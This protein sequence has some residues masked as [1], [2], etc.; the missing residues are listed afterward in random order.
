MHTETL[1]LVVRGQKHAFF[2]DNN[3]GESVI[4][5]NVAAQMGAFPFNCCGDVLFDY[6]TKQ[7]SGLTFGFWQSY[8]VVGAWW[9]SQ[10][11]NESARYWLVDSPDKLRK[12]PVRTFA[13]YAWP[14]DIFGHFDALFFDSEYLDIAPIQLGLGEIY[15]WYSRDE[16]ERLVAISIPRFDQLLDNCCLSLFL[17]VARVPLVVP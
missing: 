9:E 1:T 6:R 12:D 8:G 10:G 16:K 13:S 14:V 3:Y 5:D 2:S 17:P 4:I 7:F 11:F 15:W